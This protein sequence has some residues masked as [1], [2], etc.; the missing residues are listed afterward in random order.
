MA[1]LP[2]FPLD[3]VLF[4]GMQFK[5]HIFEE[6]YKL[7]INR[8]IDADEPFGIVLIKQGRE[9]IG[10]RAIPCDVG[11]TAKISD[12]QRLPIGRMNILV[13]GHRRFRIRDIDRSEPYLIGEVDYF[14]PEDDRP[15]L[16]RVYS[17]RLRPL[18]I[19]YLNIL[20]SSDDKSFDPEQIPHQPRA[21]TQLA[22]IL[23]QA[24]NPQKQTLLAMDSL[25]QLA[26]VLVETY[27]LE[28]SLLKTR[29]S[30]PGSEFNIGPF[31]SN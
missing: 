22:S 17:E 18:L 10:P 16:V 7:M 15:D 11:C 3:A 27:L 29:L 12:V 25:S 23:L 31:S 9:A 19:R 21:V 6:R 24:E 30:P 1:S 28:V 2:L 5:L 20:S 26:S 8:C 4:P 14:L 13:T